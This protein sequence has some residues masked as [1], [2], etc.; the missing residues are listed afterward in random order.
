M[1]D[2]Q[3]VTEPDLDCCL[4]PDR[5]PLALAAPSLRFRSMRAADQV[6]EDGCQLFYEGSLCAIEPALAPENPEGMARIEEKCEQ[7]RAL[8][9]GAVL[10]EALVTEQNLNERFSTPPRVTL[11]G[12]RR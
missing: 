11:Y 10:G 4:A 9:D 2:R 1:Q 3:P 12:W 8:G 7:L 5:S 6:P